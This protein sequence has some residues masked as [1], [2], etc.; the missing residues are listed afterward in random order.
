MKDIIVIKIGGVAS[1]QLSGDFFSQIK[2]WQDAG[3][4]LVIVH[5][6]GFAINKL[7]EEN[8]VPVKKINGLRV[9]SKDDMVLVSHAL[10]DLVGKN[11]QEKLRQAG[12]SCQQLKSDI[13]HVVAADYLDKDTY[14]YVGD[15]THI[16]KR[17]IEEFLENRQIPIIASLGYSKEGDMLNINADYLATAV[18]VALAADKLILMTDVKGVLENGAVLEKITSHQVQEKIDT[19]VITAGMI[20]KIESAAK[21]VAAGVGQ[22]LI[23]DNLLTGTLI[24]AD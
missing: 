16:N 13:K 14:G 5:G 3:K 23:G 12:V 10:L 21:T 4:Q 15:V 2:N 11:L 19:A 6:G 8:Q 24:T 7:M 1:Q 17:V 9:T 18:A 20:P 22:V